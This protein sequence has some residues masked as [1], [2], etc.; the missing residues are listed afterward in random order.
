MWCV[1]F[2]RIAGVQ[3]DLAAEVVFGGEVR[4]EEILRNRLSADII[5]VLIAAAR[6]AGEIAQQGMRNFE[7]DTAPVRVTR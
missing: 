5:I 2:I 3:H 1:I 4:G 7:A 6:F